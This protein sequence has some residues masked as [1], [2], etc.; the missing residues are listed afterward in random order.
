MR[1]GAGNAMYVATDEVWRWRNGRGEAYPERFWVQLLRSL[2]RPALGS[3]GEEVRIAVEPA[4]ATVGDAVRIEVELP[5]GAPPATVPLEA[6]PED[7]SRATIEIDASPAPG[8]GFVVRWVPETEGRWSIRPR[9]PALA[10]RAGGG[11]AFESVRSDRE[12]RDAEVDRALLEAL[13]R[14][15]GGRVVGPADARGLVHTLPN[16]SVRTADPVQ[17]RLWNSPAALML[18]LSLLGAEWAIRRKARLA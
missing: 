14:E 15:T 3:G 17:D 2:A 5:S 1:F 13:A 6:V 10:A 12:L 9:D 11:A 4:R 18:V 16:R 7:R 8:G